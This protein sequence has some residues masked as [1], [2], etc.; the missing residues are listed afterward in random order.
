MNASCFL[1]GYVTCSLLVF[2][3]F[4]ILGKCVQDSPWYE[5]QVGVLS[6]DYSNTT[7]NG[8]IGLSKQQDAT[9]REIVAKWKVQ[10]EKLA[11]SSTRIR[12]V[13]KQFKEYE[14]KCEALLTEK[15]KEKVLRYN[16][17]SSYGI[18]EAGL[19]EKPHLQVTSN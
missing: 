1:R 13:F 3:N 12:A 4:S 2:V 17:I 19:I 8:F 18:E 9:I 16:L 6:L 14:S 15:Q 11:N 10:K 5:A 7:F